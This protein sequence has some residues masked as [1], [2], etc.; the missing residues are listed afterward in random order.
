[1]IISD[2]SDIYDHLEGIDDALSLCVEEIDGCVHDLEE[3]GFP[4]SATNA[5]MFA[6]RLKHRGLKNKKIYPGVSTSKAVTTEI[7]HKHVK[8][9]IKSDENS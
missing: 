2:G 8:E 4:A 7:E 9:A 1:M 6:M 3:K 5:I